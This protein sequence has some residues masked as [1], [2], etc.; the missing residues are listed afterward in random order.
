MENTDFCQFCDSRSRKYTVLGKQLSIKNYLCSEDGVNYPLR[1]EKAKLM[2]SIC[3]TAFCNASCK[4]CIATNTHKKQKADL[5]KLEKVLR[6]LKEEDVVQSLSFTGGEPFYD[7][8]LLDSIVSMVFDIFGKT[9]EVSISTNGTGLR[10]IH[11]I[12]DLKYVDAIHVSRHHY[13]DEIN[14]SIFGIKMPSKQELTE[15]VSTVS[16][17]DIFVFNCMLLKDY[18]NSREEAHNFL[19]FSIDVGVPKVAFMTCTPINDYAREQSID[20]R[21][22]I[23]EDDPM[24][25]FTRGFQDYEFC[26][27]RDGVYV[28]KEGRV[29]EFYGRSTNSGNCDYCRGIVYGADNCL[30]VG[31]AGEIIWQG[32][33]KSDS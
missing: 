17:K 30:R 20:F 4:F 12:K 5:V 7:I 2:L 24:I 33:E 9:L 14:N 6:L 29:T 28:S 23:T 27:C 10:D 26:R 22:V 8:G 15:I 32:D 16:F 3:P 13:D 25:M 21:S 1:P 31:Y 18:I 11:K 19:D